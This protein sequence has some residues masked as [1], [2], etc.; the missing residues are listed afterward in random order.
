MSTLD[1][2]RTLR[3]TLSDVREA[4]DENAVA[5]LA[6]KLIEELD[7]NLDSALRTQRASS[8]GDAALVGH[9]EIHDGGMAV[10]A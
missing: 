4:R 2:I 10:L 3:R 6:C 8:S 1:L 7:G 5:E 9:E